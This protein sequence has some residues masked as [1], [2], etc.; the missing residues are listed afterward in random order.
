MN[1]GVSVDLRCDL[2]GDQKIYP[3]GSWQL[4]V[5]QPLNYGSYPTLVMTFL[6]DDG[7]R[8]FGDTLVCRRHSMAIVTTLKDDTTVSEGRL[9]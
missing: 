6:F 2:C 4:A 1:G 8:F 3:V 9:Q 7:W 5:T